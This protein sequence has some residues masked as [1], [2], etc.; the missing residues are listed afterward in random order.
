MLAWFREGWDGWATLLATF[1][2]LVAV[3]V[4]YEL[5][6]RNRRIR[7]AAALIA[8]IETGFE[9]QTQELRR[10]KE[11]VLNK[12]RDNAQRFTAW[13][14]KANYPIYDNVSSDLLLLPEDTLK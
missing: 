13:G 10:E 7:L 3:Y 9:L 11:Y 12:I 14:G 5:N 1:I 2:G 6:K 8:E 4:Q